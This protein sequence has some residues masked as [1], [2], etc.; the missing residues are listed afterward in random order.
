MEDAI[1]V[2]HVGGR[3]GSR[4]FP[5][6]KH[7]EADILNIMYEVDQNCIDQIREYWKDKPSKTLVFPYCLG[8]CNGKSLIN[9]TYDPNMSSVF[10]LNPMYREFYDPYPKG[11]FDYILGQAGKVVNSY[12]TESYSLDSLVGSNKELLKPDFLSI[13]T[14]GSELLILK[15]CKTLLDE[16]ILGVFVEVSFSQIYTNQAVFGDI[17]K[18]LSEHSFEIIDLKLMPD[19]YPMTGK[20]GFRG[21]GYISQGEALFLKRPEMVPNN[22][23]L[24][25]LAFLS[26]IYNQFEHAQK[27]LKSGYFEI[28]SPNNC[29]KY[30]NFINALGKILDSMPDRNS[31]TF[32]DF[33]PTFEKSN[34]RFQI[35]SHAIYINYF[36][37]YFLMKIIYRFIIRYLYKPLNFPKRALIHIFISFKIIFAEKLKFFRTDVENL[38]YKYGLDS[39]L[40]IIIKNRIIDYK[41]QNKR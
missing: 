17:C 10:E 40:K 36:A 39:Q 2:H 14:Q 19:L 35:K 12:F 37:R 31:P 26:C 33:Y 25:K 13:D 22:I 15:G 27:C 30:I 8:E 28:S 16:S 38:F 20:Y 4:D 18:L 11:G 21:E 23:Q 9:I 7:F 5:Y 24:H 41:R 3:S 29:Y 1:K 6:L 34:Q 32:F